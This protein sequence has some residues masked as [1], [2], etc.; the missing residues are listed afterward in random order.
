MAV[1]IRSLE[2]TAG[3]APAWDAFV[4]ANPEASFFH[5]S[6]WAGVIRRHE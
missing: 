6:P 4:Q 2:D 1:R 3:A 5:L